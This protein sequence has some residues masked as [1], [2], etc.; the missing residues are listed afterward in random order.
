[1]DGRLDWTAALVSGVV[2]VLIS[3][4]AVL[5]PARRATRIAPLAAVRSDEG[6][7]AGRAPRKWAVTG[8]V[9]LLILWIYLAVWPPGEWSGKHQPWDLIL[10]NVLFVPWLV[11]LTLT[12]PAVIGVYRRAT[13]GLLEVRLGTVGRLAADNLGR[14]RMRVTLTVITF[15]MGI[16]MMVGLNGILTFTNDVLVGRT[17]EKALREDQAWFIYPFDRGSG[18]EQFEQLASAAGTMLKP[19]VRVAVWERFEGRAGVGEVYNVFIPE[20]SVPM[21]GFPTAIESVELLQRPG[22][23]DFIEGDWETAATVMQAG[24]GVLLPPTGAEVMGASVGD[25]ITLENADH[26]VE[27]TVAGI[28]LGGMLPMAY[29]S[30]AAREAFGVDENPGV[31]VVWPQE[32]TDVKAL[33]DELEVLTNDFEGDA[34]LS[35][36]E[37]ELRSILDVSDQLEGITYGLL[38]LAVGAAALGMVNTTM[39]SVLQRRPE[40]GVL[41]GVGATRQQT[42]RIIVGEAALTGLLGGALGMVTGLGMTVINAVSYGGLRFSLLEMN[43]WQAAWESV[44]NVLPAGLWGMVITPLIGAATAWFPARGIL[45]EKPVDILREMGE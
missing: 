6:E 3:V 38:G 34:F 37:G 4:L 19:E 2:G 28:G 11:G 36:P 23:F 9:I 18:L 30:L 25:T 17:A 10:P 21:P 29:L 14:E 42:M 5:V 22:A 12:L 20:L 39:M 27:C 24:C 32:G 33:E 31:M 35:T 8:V 45:R 26:V 41:R 7:G 44:A 15:A 40:F 43:L 16:A 1:G 13:R